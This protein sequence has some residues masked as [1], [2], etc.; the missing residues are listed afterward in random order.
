MA[1][2][3]VEARLKN[4][5]LVREDRQILRNID[6]TIRPGERWLLAGGNGAGKTQLLKLIA[7][8]VWPT[9][10]GKEVREYFWRNEHWPSPLEVQHEIA[11]VGPERQDKYE[12][13]GWNF[14]AAR[15]IGTGLYRTD[16]PL[17]KLND[18]DQRT[19]A[20]LLKR[21]SIE[22]LA[23]REFLTLSYGERRLTLLARALATRPKLLLLDELLN[24]LDV[25][26]HAAAMKWLE[27]TGRSPLPW[28]LA[29]HRFEDLPSI[30]THA[31][32][33]QKGRVIYS[34]K[35][36][37]APLDKWLERPV[38]R[39]PAGSHAV[40]GK[41]RRSSAIDSDG[42]RRADPSTTQ[43][44]RIVRLTNA[45]VF[46]DERQVLEGITLTLNA[47]DCWVVHGPNGS[48]K[49]TLLR[50]IYGD[51]GI[52]DVGQIERKGVEP[53]VPIQLFKQKVGF[54]AP[55]LQADHP[56]ELSV[57]EV[58][59][60]GR[61]ASIG[62]NDRPT[63]TDQSAARSALEFFGLAKFET[64]TLRELS[65][66]QLRRVLFARAWVN[67][68]ELLLL[69]EPFAGI[70]APTRRFLLEHVDQLLASGTTVM[71][72]THHREEWPHRATH[73][74]ELRNGRAVYC[75]VVRSQGIA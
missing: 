30:A 10:T 63:A 50:A 25:T 45:A 19:I 47:G 40:S 64:R 27:S 55:H 68:P 14:T 8:A 61:H 9:P 34:G 65:Y 12:R 6:W 2:S 22:H 23:D 38:M 43:R 1:G 70:D 67:H 58:V 53:G 39:K 18:E 16:I 17:D 26:N 42:A 49:S 4:I 74:L 29:T 37:D 31:L 3:F 28:V 54:V 15:I 32:V 60:S 7:G 75:G 46:L 73:E 69:D 59:Q 21:L 66:G 20:R 11:Y 72:A 24:G 41:S 62:L 71:I 35:F 44:P 36:A 56:Q 5:C 33:L 51:Y 13:Y 52:A 57:A 48:G